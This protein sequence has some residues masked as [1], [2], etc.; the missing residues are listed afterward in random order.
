MSPRSYPHCTLDS[1]SSQYPNP[2]APYLPGERGRVDY[3]AFRGRT[4]SELAR[5]AAG[6]SQKQ[7][8]RA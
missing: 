3:L 6:E 8:R 2:L 1:R 5:E 4:S 7:S